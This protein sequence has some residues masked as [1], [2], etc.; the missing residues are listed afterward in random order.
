[1]IYVGIDYEVNP[2][3][4]NLEN[5]MQVPVPTP[6]HFEQLED[7]FLPARHKDLMQP[8]LELDSGT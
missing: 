1:M 7:D 3:T 8:W 5:R 4:F 2:K 6:N